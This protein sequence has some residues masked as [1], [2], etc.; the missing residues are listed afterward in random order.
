MCTIKN[1]SIK[2]RYCCYTDCDNSICR[3]APTSAPSC[4]SLEYRWNALSPTQCVT[5]LT[6]NN[7]QNISDYCPTDGSQEIVIMDIIVVVKSVLTVLAVVKSAQ[8]IIPVKSSVLN[9]ILWS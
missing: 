1:E 8:I 9:V 5:N 4:L 7:Y 6:T 2:S 3:D